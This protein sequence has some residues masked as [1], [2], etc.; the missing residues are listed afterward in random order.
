MKLTTATI[1][2][3]MTSPL[4]NLCPDNDTY[5]LVFSQ[6]SLVSSGDQISHSLPVSA[7]HVAPEP[8]EEGELSELQDQLE[9][10]TR[11]SDRP[12]Q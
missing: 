12:D 6:P 8:T 3:E 4:E 10:D 9:V 2:G 11:D 5:E 1:S 7:S